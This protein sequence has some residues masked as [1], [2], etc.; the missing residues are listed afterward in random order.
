MST[1]SINADNVLHL[2]EYPNKRG[3]IKATHQHLF[4]LNKTVLN[5]E[6]EGQNLGGGIVMLM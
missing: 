2:K 1:I 3:I 6:A 4:S 5:T